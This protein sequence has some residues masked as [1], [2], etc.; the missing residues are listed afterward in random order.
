M[1]RYFLFFLIFFSFILV[2]AQTVKDSLI[3]SGTWFLFSSKIEQQVDDEVLAR[4]TFFKK[5]DISSILFEDKNRLFSVFSEQGDEMNEDLWKMLDDNR[6]VMTNLT[7]ESAQVMEII[8]YTPSKLVIRYCED[9]DSE[10]FICIISTY[11][12]TKSGWLPDAEIDELNTAGV[13]EIDSM[14]P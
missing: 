4:V 6:F 10:G 9:S 11:F 2:E 13:L 12:A 1:K 14:T 3:S 8:E 5:D 7:G